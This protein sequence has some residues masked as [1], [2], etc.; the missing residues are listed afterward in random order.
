MEKLFLRYSF[1]KEIMADIDCIQRMFAD[2]SISYTILNTIS[3][4][5]SDTICYDYRSLYPSINKGVYYNEEIYRRYHIFP[6]NIYHS[7]INKEYDIPEVKVT[8]NIMITTSTSDEQSVPYLDTAATVVKTKDVQK[9]SVSLKDVQK[10]SV[11]DGEVQKPS[12]SDGEVQNNKSSVSSKQINEPSVS[13]KQINEPKFPDT[14]S[15]ICCQTKIPRELHTE[16]KANDS[17]GECNICFDDK[18][19]PECKRVF[20]PCGHSDI[21][22]SCLETLLKST[23]EDEHLSCPMCRQNVLEITTQLCS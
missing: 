3:D 12:V 14:K 7:I 13:A 20:S 10:S 11:S 5:I 9:S 23:K 17:Y 4:T 21:C 16:V 15:S 22:D 8:S 6:L 1:V 18:L 19:D 2:N